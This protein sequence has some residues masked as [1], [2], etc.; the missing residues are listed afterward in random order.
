MAKVPNHKNINGESLKLWNLSMVSMLACLVVSLYNDKWN[1]LK[2][3]GGMLWH[4]V[5][6][7]AKARFFVDVEEHKTDNNNTKIIF[8]WTKTKE[9]Q[10]SYYLF[11][12]SNALN[13]YLYG[14]HI[15]NINFI[16]EYLLC[17]S[18]DHNRNIIGYSAW[19][20]S[21]FPAKSYF[22]IIELL[23]GLHQSI[24]FSTNQLVTQRT[25]LTT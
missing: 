19:E 6:A 17:P 22:F 21:L 9:T 1:I 11:C 15:Q 18:N 2:I 10:R 14:C 13:F 23:V 4:S 12:A 8:C 25:K 7:I 20:M 3:L 16:N 5:R 24:E